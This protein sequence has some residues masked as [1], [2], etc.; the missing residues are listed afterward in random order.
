LVI[1]ISTHTSPCELDTSSNDTVLARMQQGLQECKNRFSLNLRRATTLHE[2]R[3]TVTGMIE[4][5][6]LSVHIRGS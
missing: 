2:V 3:I 1:V 4:N 5:N 6:T